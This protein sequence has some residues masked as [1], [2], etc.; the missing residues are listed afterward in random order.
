ME[1]EGNK[2]H[3]TSEVVPYCCGLMQVGNF[4]LGGGKF[5]GHT[6]TAFKRDCENYCDS[7][8]VNLLTATTTESQHRIEKV[9]D[10]TPGWVKGTS[11]YSRGTGN[12]ITVW[13][14][15]ADDQRIDSEEE[16]DNM[17]YEDGY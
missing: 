12:L 1:Q 9:M 4:I 2:L 13:Y 17:D 11:F 15:K 7:C 16:E 3:S 14:Y 8:G 5:D 6:A 10:A